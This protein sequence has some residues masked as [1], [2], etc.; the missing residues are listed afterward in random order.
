MGTHR[1]KPAYF[2]CVFFCVFTLCAFADEKESNQPTSLTVNFLLHP[3]LVLFDG[4]PVNIELQEAVNRDEKFQLVEIAHSQPLFGWVV[5]SSK[6][7]TLQSAYRV[8]VSSN[9]SDLQNDSGDVWDSGKVESDQSINVK[10]SG[11][12]LIPK[13]VY[14]WKVKTWDN[15]GIESEF[16]T[17]EQFLTAEELSVYP[18]VTTYPLNKQDYSPT[19]ITKLADDYTLI[20]FDKAR[21][22]RLRINLFGTKEIDTVSIHLG[23]KVKDGKIDRNPEG[24]VRYELIKVLVKPGWHTYEVLIPPHY[25]QGKPDRILRMPDYIGKVMP[26]RYCEIGNYPSEL[27]TADKV[28]QISVFY[29]FDEEA[30]S[31]YSSD[32]VLNAVWEMCKHTIKATSFCG[33]YVDGDRERF[34]READSYLAQMTHYGVEREFS[35]ARYTH[36][37][38]IT[39]SSQWTEWLMHVVLMAWEDFMETGDTSSMAHYYEDLKAKTLMDLAREDGLIS[40]RTGLV[41]WDV[42]NAVHWKKTEW[43]RQKKDMPNFRDIVDWPQ[44]GELGLSERQGETDDF[45]FEDINTVVNAFHFRT[46]VL[47][48]RIAKQLG[49]NEEALLFESQAELVKRSFNKILLDKKTGIYVDGEGSTHS[50]LHANM[51]A[52]TFGLAPEKNL[53][54]IVEFIKSRGLAYSPYGALYLLESL[55]QTGKA[56]YALDLMT[57]QSDRGWARWIYE[58]GATN[59]LESWGPE[60]KPNLDWSHAWGSAPGTIIPRKLMGIEPIEPGYRKIRIKPQ[61]G[62]LKHAEIELPTIRGDVHVAFQ[63]V[64]GEK[65]ELNVSIP[66]NMQADVFLPK[67]G[68]RIVLLMNE[69]PIEFRETEGFVIAKNIGSGTRNFKLIVKK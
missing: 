33:M 66:A 54:K 7:N 50:S 26:F 51:F 19:H 46:L 40:T 10:Y 4:Y 30:S 12:A 56:D 16:S 27:I 24:S 58:F 5:N 21:F 45:E 48:E 13:T 64:P 59:A 6:S 63:N 60:F 36:E 22:G 8:L 3:D 44:S 42:I 37:F 49:K 39:Y 52:V 38:Q 1:L 31:F 11:K 57:Q 53:P 28:Q 23:E 35:L 14:F 41:T 17:T 32:T 9:L 29:P 20:D 65:F 61:P 43:Q 62:W 25:Y 69:E 55:F 47:M 2:I 15:Q 34:P 18:G 68:G 67:S